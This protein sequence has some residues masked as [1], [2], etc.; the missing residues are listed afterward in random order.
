MWEKGHPF[1]ARSEDPSVIHTAAFLTSY[2]LG[3]IKR[4]RLGVQILS[5]KEQ[6]TG[7]S[8]SLET[9]HMCGQHKE[10]PYG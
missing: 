5:H 4:I 7:K 8:P 6:S 1:R 9:L 3:V 10:K 2:T